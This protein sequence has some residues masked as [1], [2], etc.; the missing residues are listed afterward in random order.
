MKLPVI[1][2][3]NS[4]TLPQERYNADWALEQQV[5]LVV[6]SF[7]HITQT[8]AQLLE[9]ANFARFRS[10]AAAVNNRAVLEIPG[11]LAEILE[12]ATP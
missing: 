12:K 5:G 6:R 11:M 10:H 9:P 8:V 1:V 2:E 3:R 4:R 7:R